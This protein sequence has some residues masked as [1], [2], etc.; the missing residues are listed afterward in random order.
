VIRRNDSASRRTAGDPSR[1]APSPEIALVL[2][3][4][5]YRALQVLGRGGMGEIVEAEHVT[6]G[7]RVVVKLLHAHHAAD[8]QLASRLR[9][10]AQ[11][12]ARLSHENLVAVHDLGRTAAG[13]PF[14]VM[15]RLAGRTLR[16]ELSLRGA[17]PVAEALALARQALAGLSVA[18]AAGVVHR[19]VKLDNLFLC[20]SEGGRRLLKVIDFGVAKRV[21]AAQEP[22]AE[23][24][25]S[26]QK[27]VV[28]GTPRFLS[29]EQAR[30]APVDARSDLYAMGV[31]LYALV[32]GRGP[33]DHLNDA[34][35]L[36]RAHALERPD[37]PSRHA[38][39]PLPAALEHAIAKAMAKQPE[40][41]FQSALSFAEALQEIER[42]LGTVPEGERNG[43]DVLLTEPL[44]ARPPPLLTEPLPA[45]LTTV[46]VLEGAGS[47]SPLPWSHRSAAPAPMAT[48]PL[49]RAAMA[50]T[51]LPKRTMG[52]SAPAPAEPAEPARTWL[53]LG[54]TM[55]LFGMVAALLVL[56]WMT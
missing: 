24:E 39:A 32:A 11:A 4:T 17:L 53:V 33:F 35:A 20:V 9:V 27:G 31:V 49:P 12:L 6:L 21:D 34:P 7:K 55:A 44:P 2:E 25:V 47:L 38:P 54:L 41:R 50:K 19:D 51:E 13:R 3:G 14:Y 48:V 15:D 22:D 36:A 26:T 46:P 23:A 43:M 5:P 18:H 28:V 29:P 42:D 56:W 37:P 8:E 30:G 52:L 40:E 10:E 16:E 1:R 45:R